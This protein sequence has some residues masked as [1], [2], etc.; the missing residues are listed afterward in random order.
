MGHSDLNGN[1]IFTKDK[2]VPPEIM[3]AENELEARYEKYRAILEELTI[4]SDIF[5]RNVL[6]SQECT[7]FI[8]QVIMKKKD[9]KVQEQ[10]IQ[11]DFRRFSQNLVLRSRAAYSC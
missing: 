4:M 5:M 1:N 2:G 6:K 7:E 10:V 3:K 9:L 8:L 11:P